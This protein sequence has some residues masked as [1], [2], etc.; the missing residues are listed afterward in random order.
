MWLDVRSGLY[1]LLYR[2]LHDY[3]PQCID[4]APP[5]VEGWKQK[6]N[7]SDQDALY[8]KPLFAEKSL[9]CRWHYLTTDTILVCHNPLEYEKIDDSTAKIVLRWPYF[10]FCFTIFWCMVYHL[11]N[12]WLARPEAVWH[13]LESL[14]RCMYPDLTS[15]AETCQKY[16][17][18][19]FERILGIEYDIRNELPH[20]LRNIT[21]RPELKAGGKLDVLRQ[22]T[23]DFTRL[24]QYFR[25][26][27]IDQLTND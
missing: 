13:K 5:T 10:E 6:F 16:Y 22:R 12:A 4:C 1:C 18:A 15:D 23:A 26:R 19:L 9:V 14:A 3:P 11:E 2:A 7:I 27:V 21:T 20:Y 8:I 25:E 17:C 24:I